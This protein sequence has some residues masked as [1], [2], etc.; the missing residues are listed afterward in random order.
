MSKVAGSKSEDAAAIYLVSWFFASTCTKGNTKIVWPEDGAMTLPMYFLAKKDKLNKTQNIVDYIVS[1]EFGEHCVKTN[2]PCVNG[3]V[4]SKLPK[5]AKFK[6]LG[7]DYIREN[8][9]IETAKKCE[10]IFMKYWSE[11]H[12]N[13]EIFK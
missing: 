12:E 6:W 1:K 9:I 5:G 13:M 4:D 10:N 8:N 2:T 3:N 11:Y 7:W